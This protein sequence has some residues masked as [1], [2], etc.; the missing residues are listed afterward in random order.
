MLL[1]K[2]FLLTCVFS[3]CVLKHGHCYI[4]RSITVVKMIAAK[5]E[6][7]R[8]RLFTFRF[9]LVR[10][11]KLLARVLNDPL[12]FKLVTSSLFTK[13]QRWPP[14]SFHVVLTTGFFSRFVAHS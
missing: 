7:V 9:Q 13:K 10:V 3:A 5:C 4:P 14:D 12:N 2:Q 6:F 1:L 11:I 8:V